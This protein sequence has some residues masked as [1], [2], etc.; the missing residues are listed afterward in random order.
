MASTIVPPAPTAQ[1]GR[2]LQCRSGMHRWFASV[3][4]GLGVLAVLHG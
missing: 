1:N 2:Q 4:F 3:Y